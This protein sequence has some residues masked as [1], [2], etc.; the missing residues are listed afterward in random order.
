MATNFPKL[1]GYMPNH[2]PT[3]VSHKRVSHAKLEQIRNARNV[4][5][6]LHALPRPLEKNYLPEKNEQSKSMSHTQFPNHTG[7]DIKEHFEPTFVKLDR[8]VSQLPEPCLRSPDP[9]ISI[10]APIL[11]VLQG[12]CS[13][14]PT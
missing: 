9:S 8:Q 5:V 7:E 12:K 6:P 2:D 11:R 10:G 14:V 4:I 3:Q 13:R 1:P